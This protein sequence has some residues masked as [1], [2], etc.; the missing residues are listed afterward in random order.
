MNRCG[1]LRKKK[2]K[3]VGEKLREKRKIDV[4][5]EHTIRKK[6]RKGK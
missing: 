2:K 6:E 4:R 3:A 1:E 5:T